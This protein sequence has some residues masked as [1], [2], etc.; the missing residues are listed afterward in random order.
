MIENHYDDL[1]P[2]HC[3]LVADGVH[4]VFSKCYDPTQDYTRL[5]ANLLAMTDKFLS[6]GEV[7]KPKE[8][9]VLFCA[10]EWKKMLSRSD[11]QDVNYKLVRLFHS[12]REEATHEEFGNIFRSV[13]S[14][15]MGQG[16]KERGFEFNGHLSVLQDLLNTFLSDHLAEAGKKEISHAVNYSARHSMKI[17]RD[18]IVDMMR[19]YERDQKPTNTFQVGILMWAL[20][21]LHR[22]NRQKAL[23]AFENTIFNDLLSE[24][25][26]CMEA[27][28]QQQS[29]SSSSA[30]RSV[31]VTDPIH[32]SQALQGL[33][34]PHQQEVNMQELKVVIGA[35]L[36]FAQK[37]ECNAQVLANSLSSLRKVVSLRSQSFDEESKEAMGELFGILVQQQRGLPQHKLTHSRKVPKMNE[38]AQ[39][40]SAVADMKI[41]VSSKDLELACQL[42]VKIYEESDVWAR[43]KYGGTSLAKMMYY[44]SLMDG[45]S[46]IEMGVRTR[47]MDLWQDEHREDNRNDRFKVQAASENFLRHHQQ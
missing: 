44:L 21:N 31:G 5:S 9:A 23:F 33:V 2:N 47:M 32:I 17:S 3:T 39:A 19:S 11:R 6:M 14:Y 45:V 43:N 28:Q 38:I 42:M 10:T 4:S 26:E 40:V 27:Q 34:V 24:F 30:N 18:Q 16:A 46:G 12:L 36:G 20:Y 41:D 8:V 29:S 15:G 37:G 13:C 25:I 22:K 1:L 7:A 35:L